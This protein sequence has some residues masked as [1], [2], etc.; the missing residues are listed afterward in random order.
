[1]PV[2][3]SPIV[4]ILTT[5]ANECE[6]KPKYVPMLVSFAQLGQIRV[7][8]NGGLFKN[9]ATPEIVLKAEIECK[10]QGQADVERLFVDVDNIYARNDLTVQQK[11]DLFIT[12]MEHYTIHL[13]NRWEK[14][15]SHM[16]Y[17]RRKH[18]I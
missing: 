4:N 3:S 14:N 11:I 6:W 8:I 17:S 1:M 16:C 9:V 2:H 12:R 10:K 13:L 5:V 18:S 7:A 15:D